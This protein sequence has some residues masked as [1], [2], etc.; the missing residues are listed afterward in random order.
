M[1]EWKRKLIIGLA[2]LV[3][4]FLLMDLLIMPLYVDHGATQKVPDV[5]TRTSAEAR[6]ILTTQGLEAV[7]AETKADDKAPPGTVISQN[8]QAGSEVKS[9]RRVYLTI[10]GGELMVTVPRLRGLSTR[11][12]RFALERAGLTLGGI[13]SAVS[14]TFFAN[15]V[16]GQ[17]PAA[18]GSVSK[19]SPI[20][21]TIS[22]GKDPGTV[23]IPDLTGKTMAEAERILTS[24]GLKVG[25]VT[26]QSGLNLVPN[27]VIDQYPRGGEPVGPEK[28]VDLFVVRSGEGQPESQPEF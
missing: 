9:G 14:D 3:G 22:L 17:S 26:Y 2:V 27:T 13:W 4:I 23:T 24:R 28:V 8:P 11:D 25:R 5:V 18:G 1:A 6:E 10:S 15:T 7:E 21:I 12:A 19:G 16:I 20:R